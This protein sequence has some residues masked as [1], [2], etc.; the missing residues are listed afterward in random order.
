VI[1]FLHGAITVSSLAVGLFFLRY[2]VSSRDRLFLLFCAA[3]WLLASH[4]IVLSVA[5]A[6]AGYAHIPR[7]LAFALIAVAVVDKNRK[8]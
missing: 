3:F 8:G 4:W 7:F 5:P 2:W 6:W 1:D